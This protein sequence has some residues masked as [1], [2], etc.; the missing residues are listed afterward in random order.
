MLYNHHG[1]QIYGETQIFHQPTSWRLYSFIIR[2]IIYFLPLAAFP[3]GIILCSF[4]S[5]NY[6]K[7]SLEKYCIHCAIVLVVICGQVSGMDFCTA[8]TLKKP[9][10]LY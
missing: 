4:T 6:K 7:G 8:T 3:P 5:P 9:D 10:Y 1:K 2:N